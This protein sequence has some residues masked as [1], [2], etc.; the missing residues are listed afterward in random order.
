M[1]KYNIGD[2]FEYQGFKEE[3]D[4]TLAPDGMI[5][6]KIIAIHD[7][8]EPIYV[9][10]DR[11][12]K[13]TEMTES[14]LD[15]YLEFLGLNTS[16]FAHS[17]QSNDGD[18]VSKN[19][20]LKMIQEMPEDTTI[21]DIQYALY[22]RRELAEAEE[23]LAAG[24]VYTTEQVKEHIKKIAREQTEPNT[25]EELK[26]YV[27]NRW[28]REGDRILNQDAFFM[29]ESEAVGVRFRAFLKGIQVMGKIAG[30]P[31]QEW[32]NVE[33]LKDNIVLSDEL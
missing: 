4:G 18:L 20:I 8:Q 9:I 23:D 22:I 13:Q 3:E 25:L 16:E 6:F 19:S 15:D 29:H 28:K 24:R 21:A 11:H 10:E 30:I 1:Q 14:A 12:Q 7:A 32:M 17:I 31:D 33:W 26:D 2:V 5:T 27:I